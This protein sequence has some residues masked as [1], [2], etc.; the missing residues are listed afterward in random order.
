[1]MCQWEIWD[2]TR[3]GVSTACGFVSFALFNDLVDVLFSK[4]ALDDD[5]VVLWRVDQQLV[6]LA[7]QVHLSY[8]YFFYKRQSHVDDRLLVC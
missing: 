7:N 6:H 3:G 1:M 5:E 4:S 8:A 2:R